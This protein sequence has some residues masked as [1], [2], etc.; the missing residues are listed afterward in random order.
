L[1]ISV[2]LVGEMIERETPDA[3]LL[4]V[5]GVQS[6]PPAV[7]EHMRVKAYSV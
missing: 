3:E 1:F 5:L 7:T 6:L 4:S 2:I